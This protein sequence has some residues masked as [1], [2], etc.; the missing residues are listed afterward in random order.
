MD[1]Q[2][3]IEL[4]NSHVNIAR[5]IFTR[6]HDY[7]EGQELA[8]YATHIAILTFD[9]NK[10]NLATYIRAVAREHKIKFI[11]SHRR[12]TGIHPIT[13]IP[14]GEH[15]PRDGIGRCQYYE[16]ANKI[17]ITRNVCSSYINAGEDNGESHSGHFSVDI[18]SP[19]IDQDFLLDIKDYISIL[20][21]KYATFR[22][23][24]W[25]V[26]EG[27]MSEKTEEE[28]AEQLN[29]SRDLVAKIKKKGFEKL[30]KKFKQLLI[31][32]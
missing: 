20:E 22:D 4:Y 16:S 1:E 9:K 11:R 26:I 25:I 10:G 15:Q 3:Y 12:W 13:N 2:K 29:I 30:Q 18:L 32:G 7:K 14:I 19:N 17:L 31:K 23:R 8:E 6:V 27:F 28:I 5:D 24:L 21:Q